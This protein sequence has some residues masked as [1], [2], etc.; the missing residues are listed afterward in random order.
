MQNKHVCLAVSLI[1]LVSA[2][3]AGSQGIT[4]DSNDVKAIFALGNV[5]TYHSDTLTRTADIGTPGP[6]SWDFSRLTTTSRTRLES[7]PTGSTPYAAD[8]P[9]A[10]IA[11][12]D[13]GFTYSFF[14]E[15][16]A[17]DVILKGTGYV[18]YALPGV[19]QNF[20]L[21]GAGNAYIS[22]TPLP[23]QGQ[24]VNTPPS[25]DY[26]LPLQVNAAW[27]STYTESISGS[28]QFGTLTIPFGPML[29]THTITYTV[30]AYG[31]LVLPGGQ[32]EQALRIRKADRF[33]SGA[34]SSFRVG[35]NI[36]AKNGASVQFTV[37]DTLAASGPVAVSGVQWSEGVADPVPIQ[38]AAFTARQETGG[39]V[40]L[41][42]RTVSETNNF[43]FYVQR[44]ADSAPAFADVAG[45]FIPGNG[46]TVVPREYAYTDVPGSSGTWWYRLRQVDLDGSEHCTDAVA[47]SVLT[48]AEEPLAGAFALEQNYPNPFNAGT[49]IRYS[50]GTAGAA[51]PT[52]R[53]AVYDVMGREVAVLVDEPQPPGTYAVAFDGSGCA[54]GVYAYRLEAGG[55]VAVKRFV[56]VR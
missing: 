41:A 26:T 23:A 42:W 53:L 27:T 5:I 35:Y 13:T 50:I 56:L 1:V 2:P 16:L 46:T 4:I 6:T 22:G 49:N 55:I 33:V 40:R 28:A 25:V 20:G 29:T 21:K 9:Q 8:F 36:L 30:D 54:T 14:Y 43:G 11:L 48:S 32:T 19:L 3:P 52:V 39:A 7:L 47:V 37:A 38:L 18:Y 15:A 10:T 17:T 24:W 44:R 12:R 51:S 31:T 34:T 45:A